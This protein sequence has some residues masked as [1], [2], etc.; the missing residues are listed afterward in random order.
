[1]K[2]LRP[3]ST[4]LAKRVFVMPAKAGIPGP[5]RRTCAGAP[6]FAGG[7]ERNSEFYFGARHAGLH[8]IWRRV[9]W[10]ERQ[11]VLPPEL[12]Q[13]FASDLFWRVSLRRIFR[14]LPIIRFEGNHPAG[15]I[16]CRLRPPG[17]N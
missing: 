5:R 8:R 2:E 7:D 9:E 14:Q 12:F 6:A 1:M 17:K 10:V 16:G 15:A 11:T 13:R 4:S 3:T